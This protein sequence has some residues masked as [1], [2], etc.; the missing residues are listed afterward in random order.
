MSRPYLL[1]TLIILFLFGC[2]DDVDKALV[3]DVVKLN[4]PF[5]DFSLYRYH[6]ESSM[7]FDSG[8]TVLKILSFNEK[9]DYTD[10]D[11]FVFDNHSYPFFIKWKNKDTLSVKCLIDGGVL[12]KKQSV[13]KN[14]QKWK[15]WTFEVEYY[16]QFSSG[17]NGDYSIDSYKTD[18]N[19]IQFNSNRDLPK[20]KT[21]EVILELDS[22]K[23]SLSTFKVDTFQSKTGLSFTEY[24]LKMDKNYR[25][26]DFKALQPFIV[27]KP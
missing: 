2:N 18:S 13:Q 12:A 17:T 27:T 15:D 24:N 14:I 3:D 7:A 22:N 10:R 5:S 23:V 8:S 1:T 4:S 11:F 20:F 19:F 9:C 25:I 26:N 16:S 6:I 21:S